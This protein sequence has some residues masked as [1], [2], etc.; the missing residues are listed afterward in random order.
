MNILLVWEQFD[1][2]LDLFFISTDDQEVIDT[3]RSVNRQL[4]NVY[5][6]TPDLEKVNLAVIP[7]TFEKY[8]KD[9]VSELGVDV[10]A[11][12]YRFNDFKM[13]NME[14]NAPIDLIVCSGI[15]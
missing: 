7:K 10:K 11:W 6:F 9:Y 8:Y 3:L 15:V 12:L 1:E 2:P 5:D 4:I 14:P 13:D